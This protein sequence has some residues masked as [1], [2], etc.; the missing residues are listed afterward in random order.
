MEEN[1]KHRKAV[2]LCAGLAA[3][4]MNAG[5]GSNA[6]QPESSQ[7]T[8]SPE[9]AEKVAAQN[10]LR[11]RGQAAPNAVAPQASPQ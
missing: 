10:L 5:C 1:M 9:E 7:T 4:I 11:E 2:L 3:I 8:M 6:P